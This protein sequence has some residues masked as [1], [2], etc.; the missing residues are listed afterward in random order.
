MRGVAAI[1]VMI[2]HFSPFLSDTVVLPGAYLARPGANGVNPGQ[3]YIRVALVH[4]LTTTEAALQRIRDI[5]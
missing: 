4:D 1:S 3:D 2:Y 5:L